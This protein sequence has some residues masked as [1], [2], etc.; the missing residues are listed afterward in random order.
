M[1]YWILLTALIGCLAVGI[2]LSNRDGTVAT[3]GE[4][5]IT[6][7]GVLLFLFV[8][9]TIVGQIESNAFIIQIESKREAI[10]NARKSGN[11]IE[12]AALTLDIAEMNSTLATK[13]WVN[14]WFDGMIPDKIETVEKLNFKF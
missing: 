3:G 5:I 14:T 8:I 1:Y 2:F 4:I 13:K 10:N 12:N 11:P 6:I 7:G 9:F